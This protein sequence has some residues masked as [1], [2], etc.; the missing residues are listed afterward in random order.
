[1]SRM[2]SA[3]SANEWLTVFVHMRIQAPIVLLSMASPIM[4]SAAVVP[5]H[6]FDWFKPDDPLEEVR[7]SLD[8]NASISA[9]ATNS[10]DPV[11]WRNSWI[12]SIWFGIS[13]E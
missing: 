2:Q 3:S 7:F 1:M 4:A 9:F 10:L 5:R 12:A 13:Q 8:A 6:P 11:N